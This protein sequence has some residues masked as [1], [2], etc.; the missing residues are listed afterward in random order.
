MTNER[1]STSATPPRHE[2]DPAIFV[3]SVPIRKELDQLQST[4]R[5]LDAE[6]RPGTGWVP[7]SPAQLA[8]LLAA[9]Q[10]T[11]SEI[12]AAKPCTIMYIF[13]EELHEVQGYAQAL[14]CAL[15]D[16]LAAGLEPQTQV[17]QA[18]LLAALMD[19]LYEIQKTLWTE[20]QLVRGGRLDPLCE[21]RTT[22][23]GDGAEAPA[24]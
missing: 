24:G 19:K 10:Q 22:A 1:S 18:I 4:V 6:L 5:R 8:N 17:R 9:V 14:D 3:D 21:R 7:L 12:H 13:L 16:K 11:L 15:Q 20:Q 23:S 2:V